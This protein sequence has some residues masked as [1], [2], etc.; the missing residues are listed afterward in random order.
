MSTEVLLESRRPASPSIVRPTSL[1]HGGRRSFLAD[2]VIEH[3]PRDIL[4]RLFLQAD[5]LLRE[6]GVRISFA[7]V[8]E[9]VAVNRANPE[10]WRPIL[11]LYDPEISAIGPENSHALLG[12]NAAGEVVCAHGCRLYDLGDTTLQ[13]EIESLR[14]FYR[15]PERT[16]GPGEAMVCTAPAAAATSGRLVFTGAVWYRPDY[17]KL[18]IMPI[19]STMNRAVLATRWGP[20]FVFSFMAADLV[21][22]GVAQASRM[23]HAEDEIQMIRTPVYREGVL[24]A[25][26]VW[27]TAAE[28]NQLFAEFVAQVSGIRNTQVDRRIENRTTDKMLAG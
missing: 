4:G 27:C 18:G 22:A 1:D 11:P 16:R 21:K 23:P 20:E 8:D 28:Y 25:A 9:L 7:A 14:L 5:T 2:V 26:L 19:F 13:S 6:K 17:R 10:S 3:G 12:W 24:P 15:D